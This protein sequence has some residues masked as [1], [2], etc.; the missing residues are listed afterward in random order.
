MGKSVTIQWKGQPLTYELIDNWEDYLSSGD[1]PRNQNMTQT[2]I[3]GIIG[4]MSLLKALGYVNGQEGAVITSLYRDGNPNSQ[5]AKGTAV[6]IA[7][8]KTGPGGW[9]TEVVSQIALYSDDFNYGTQNSGIGAWYTGVDH[10]GTGWHIHFD[11]YLGGLC[12][13]TEEEKKKMQAEC[14]RS[15]GSPGAKAPGGGANNKALGPA[16]NN[17]TVGPG[18]VEINPKG[19]TYCEPVYPDY[20]YV[21]GNIPNTAVEDTVVN[22]MDKMDKAGDYG[23]MTSTVM[24]DLTG[25]NGNAFTTDKAQKLAQRPFDPQNSISEVKLPSGGKPLNNNDPFPVDLKIEELENHQPRVKQYR[26]PFNREHQETKDIAAAVLTLSDFTE[27][28]LVKL[29]NMLATITRYVFGMG[30]RMHINCIYYGGQDHR[31]WE[32]FK[33]SYAL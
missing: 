6:D 31:S 28:R 20:V 18:W 25:I 22:G 15:G 29:E 1:N 5:H 16:N 21:Q 9:Y 32:R 13:E 14:L 24:Q 12:G 8:G 23:L 10:E 33:I 27:K 17:I 19:K 4:T 3:Q 11:N 30:K 7:D 2:T 26:L